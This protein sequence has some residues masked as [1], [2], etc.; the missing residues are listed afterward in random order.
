MRVTC[1]QLEI[2]DRSKD[3][4][5]REV[6]AL[7]DE[8]RGSD[9]V[10]LPELWPCGYFNFDR[11]GEE[12]EAI[13]G[14]TVT[15]LASKARELGTHVWMGSFVERDG[16]HLFNT[17]LLFD[18]EGKIV[19]RYRKMHL[20]SYNSREKELLKPGT[21]VVVASLPWGRTGLS[22]CYDVRFPELFRRMLDEQARFFLISA[23]WP[24]ERVEAWRVLCTARAIENASYVFAC[25]A[26][27]SNAGVAI[28]GHSLIIDPLGRIVAEGGDGPGIVSAEIEPSLPDLIRFSFPAVDDRALR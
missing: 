21:D 10:L 3:D 8:C 14:P 28:A 18:S 11:Y 13:D 23:A 17:A 24:A 26:A 5:V 7:L 27:G 6:L 20:F 1:V 4:R 9:L 12:S 25:N 19:A 16:D 15:A 22:I 2:G